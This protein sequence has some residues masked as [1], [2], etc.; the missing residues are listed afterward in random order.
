[1]GSRSGDTVENRVTGERVVVRIGS[2][3]TNGERIVVDLFVKPTGRVAAPHFHPEIEE[4]FT[5]ISGTVG[6]R[7]GNT[8]TIAEPGQRIVV[9]PNVVHDWWN[10]GDTEA[11]V[12]IEIVPAT[13]FELMI[14]NLFSLANEGK[15]NAKGMPNILQLAMLAREF[16]DVIRFTT[17]PRF[18]Q[19]AM[20]GILATIAREL[21]YQG[22]YPEYS[23]RDLSPA[24]V[25][26][27]DVPAQPRQIA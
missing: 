7:L 19:R 2:E 5:I 23:S 12:L 27:N 10:A 22:S 17:P 8:E 9:A 1:M 6:V 3:E 20:F 14:Q 4:V 13:R 18:L 11:H 25:R 26:E 15:T 16:D 21:G 24:L